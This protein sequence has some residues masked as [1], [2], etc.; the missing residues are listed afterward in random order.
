MFYWKLSFAGKFSFAEEVDTIQVDPKRI[1]LLMHFNVWFAVFWKVYGECEN[2][3]MMTGH[4]GAVTEMH[5]TTDG[6]HLFT[7]STDYTLGLWDFEGGV[8]I[9]K[10][11]G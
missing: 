5:F 10:L 8:R 1:A 9:K 7:S 3:G 11:K 2:V 4:T 6:C